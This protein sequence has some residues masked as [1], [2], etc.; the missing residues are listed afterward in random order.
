VLSAF[1]PGFETVLFAHNGGRFD[2]HFVLQALYR[3][4][5]APAVIMTGLKIY[6]IKVRLSKQTS[7]LRFRDSY[8]ILQTPLDNLKKTFN[9][10]VEEKMFFPYLFC[11]EANKDVILPTLPPM[12]DYFPQSMKMDKNAK[13]LKWCYLFP[14]EN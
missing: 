1:E 10:D 5:L 3:K 11:A 2:A 13:F 7:Q 6:E 14:F 8:L 9:L 12:T 4:K